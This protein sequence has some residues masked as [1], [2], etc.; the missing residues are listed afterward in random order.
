MVITFALRAVISSCPPL[1]MPSRH[2]KHPSCKGGSGSLRGNGPSYSVVGR[3]A[4][5]G[6]RGA[7]RV[8]DGS[9]AQGA[10]GLISPELVITTTS[11]KQSGKSC[12]I[13][14]APTQGRGLSAPT[15]G[16]R[17]YDGTRIWRVLSHIRL[18]PCFDRGG[19]STLKVSTTL[20]SK[21]S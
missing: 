17:I 12:P 3:R 18:C 6:Y 11:E 15:Q 2:C 8:G 16:A 9:R 19:R 7:G 10:G 5:P 21:R 14:V 4:G 13:A 20:S 1:Y